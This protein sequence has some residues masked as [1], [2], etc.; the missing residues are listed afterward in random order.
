MCDMV[1]DASPQPSL[2]EW[3]TEAQESKLLKVK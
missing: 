1:F 2:I 3:E